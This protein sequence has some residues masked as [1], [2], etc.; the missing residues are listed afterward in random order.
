VEPKTEGVLP[1]WAPS[2][3]PNTSAFI[4]LGAIFVPEQVAFVVWAEHILPFTF[5]RELDRKCL[6]ILNPKVANP[7]GQRL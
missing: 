3:H 4:G 5:V 2:V 6:V 1:S 7:Q